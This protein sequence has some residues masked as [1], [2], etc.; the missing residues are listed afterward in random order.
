[1]GKECLLRNHYQA[2]RPLSGISLDCLNEESFHG[3]IIV[4]G[5]REMVVEKGK[6]IL[7]R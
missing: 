1:M 3:L 7:T 4:G 5:N 6:D 2:Q